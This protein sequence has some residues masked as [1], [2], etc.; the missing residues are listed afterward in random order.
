M[1]QSPVDSDLSRFIIVLAVPA[2]GTIVLAVPIL[3][4]GPLI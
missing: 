3:Q 2:S 1:E 4:E